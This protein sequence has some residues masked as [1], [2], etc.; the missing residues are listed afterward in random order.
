MLKPRTIP[1]EN[2][3]FKYCN[4]LLKIDF[5]Q[6]TTGGRS[7]A[8]IATPINGPADPCN[9]ATATPVPDVKAHRIPIHKDRAFPLEGF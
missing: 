7:D 9:K 6:L 4:F 3:L 2:G 8:E 1:V 5:T